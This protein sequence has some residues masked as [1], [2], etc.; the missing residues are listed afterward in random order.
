MTYRAVVKVS[1]SLVINPSKWV[2]ILRSVI[3]VIQF[4]APRVW[5]IL[6]RCWMWMSIKIL[7]SNFISEKDVWCWWL[8]KTDFGNWV[9]EAQWLSGLWNY[10][11]DFYI[12]TFTSKYK[13]NDVLCFF[14]CCTRFLEHWRVKQQL[15]PCNLWMLSWPPENIV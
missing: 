11:S 7:A 12:L 8:T 5:S 15:R 14:G 3:T 1:K 13:E 2:H 4:P 6:S 10:T 9:L